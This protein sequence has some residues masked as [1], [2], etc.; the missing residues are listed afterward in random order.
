M[1]GVA[2][3]IGQAWNNLTG[4]TA[5]NQTDHNN[6]VAD[7]QRHLGD[8]DIATGS[9]YTQNAVNQANE[10]YGQNNAAAKAAGT[11]SQN[12]TGEQNAANART[13]ESM[14]A[15][16][17]EMAQKAN[18]SASQNALNAA[19][20]SGGQ[21][22]ASA[23]AA[24]LNAGQAAQMA[25]QGTSGAYQNQ[26]NQGINQYGQNVSQFQS[27]GQ[28]LAGQQAQSAS[29][30]AQF[31]SLAN[32]NAATNLG[33]G[34]NMNQGAAIKAGVSN[35][36]TNNATS[37][38]AGAQ[39]GA[40]NV[41]GAG[42][43]LAGSLMSSDENAKTDITPATG[44]TPSTSTDNPFLKGLQ[45]LAAGLTAAGQGSSPPNGSGG[46]NALSQG[47]AS[48]G[49]GLAS[50][51][52]PGGGIGSLFGGGGAS[53]AGAASGSGAGASTGAETAASS[54]PAVVGMAKGGIS[55]GGVT[56]VGEKGPELVK[57][58]QGDQ[59]YPADQTKE[60]LKSGKTALQ[61]ATS[62]E[63]LESLLKNVKPVTYKYKPGFEQLKPEGTPRMG[64]LAQDL[65]KT[66]LKDTV[67][68]TPQGK[69]LDVGQLTANNTAL[70]IELASQVKALQ[71]QLKGAK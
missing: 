36:N 28:N 38:V 22:A 9:G 63:V 40:T 32:A 1:G 26:L 14:G 11:Q 71:D 12:L 51:L 23:R 39:A 65:E 43:N 15:N 8:A 35:T 49:K 55:K 17:T 53:P 7:E 24:G 33:A 62:K 42:L 18:A 57:L 52:T 21:A 56:L 69:Q 4:V 67:V 6:Q 44:S 25:A 31:G 70:I 48:F 27:Q 41:I 60:M 2:Q 47:A 34:A 45:G 37:N 66:P 61:G 54:L 30:Q 20:A 16:A 3:G 5:Q 29:Q 58:N 59:V 10:Q 13:N 68:D 19:N 46:G 50:K 64:V